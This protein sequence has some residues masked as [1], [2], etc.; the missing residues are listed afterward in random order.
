M[1]AVMGIWPG[2]LWV[3]QELQGSYALNAISTML[4]RPGETSKL[5]MRAFA[6][7]ATSIQMGPLLLVVP[8][9]MLQAVTIPFSSQV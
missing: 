7:F 8:T 3:A 6:T 1:T 2:R 4:R 9:T 5:W